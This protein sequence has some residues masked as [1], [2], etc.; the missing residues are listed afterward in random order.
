MAHTD[1]D[2]SSN[3]RRRNKPSGGDD[4]VGRLHKTEHVQKGSSQSTS[5]VKR[6]IRL[7]KGTGGDAKNSTALTLPERAIT[8][9]SSKVGRVF[10]TLWTE[11]SSPSHDHD[12]GSDSEVFYHEKVHFKKRRFVVVRPGKRF[13]TCLPITS[14]AGQEV[15]KL[16][17]RLNEHGFIY[18]QKEPE[19]VSQM[20]LMPLKLLPSSLPS[21]TGEKLQEPSLVNYGRSYTVEMSV[22][23]RDNGV[24]DND[25]KG[26]L[27]HN[28]RKFRFE[29]VPDPSGFTSRKLD[30]FRNDN[31]GLASIHLRQL[32]DED[33]FSK[34]GSD[35][36]NDHQTPA[37]P[38]LS[39]LVERLSSS[40]SGR[41]DLPSNLAHGPTNSRT[42]SRV[43]HSAPLEHLQPTAK[44]HQTTVQ[45]AHEVQETLPRLVLKQGK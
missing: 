42:H 35:Q 2:T 24:L 15:L 40:I 23:V 38:V 34:S 27:F 6:P 8:N 20:S 37:P 13:V 39:A 22:K 26:I 4:S 19:G 14:Y 44:T 11:R 5:L 33:C 9:F 36:D 41:H 1:V 30:D 18:F 25:S 12:F 32:V 17:I 31:E 43:H 28:Y 29:E 10:S 21:W 3:V 16:G 45:E 7:V